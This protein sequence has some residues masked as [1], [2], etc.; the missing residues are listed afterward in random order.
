MKRKI[1][2]C[3]LNACTLWLLNSCVGMGQNKRS[4]ATFR[5][6]SPL[7]GTF[8]VSTVTNSASLTLQAASYD[9]VYVSGEMTTYM[10]FPENVAV[11][12]IGS[13]HYVGKIESDNMLYLK[14]LKAHV[15]PSSL[16]VRTAEE[17]IYLHYIAYRQQPKKI[18][19]DYRTDTLIPAQL[20]RS[21]QAATLPAAKPAKSYTQ[22]LTF[23]QKVPPKRKITY[24]K[25]NGLQVEVTGLALDREA[26]Y[27]RMDIKNRTS[28]PYKID[29]VGFTYEQR[30]TKKSQRRIAP[31]KMEVAP[32]AQVAVPIISPQG[33]ECLVYALPLYANAKRGFLE[34]VIRE[35]DGNRLLSVRIP[36][37]RLA[38]AQYLPTPVSLK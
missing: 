37:R 7:E 16:L 36:A 13:K 6:P 30:H 26:M 3:F 10:I 14:P 21:N 8:Q 27:V 34:I 29:Y 2:V 23:L 22:K 9:T 35:S 15:P 5:K 25:A 12:D 38:K 33:E 1:S 24:C 4:M 20:T 17:R 18:F 28:I 31:E 11:M 19:W 32:F